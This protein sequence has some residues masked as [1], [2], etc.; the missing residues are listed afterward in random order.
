MENI[1]LFFYEARQQ[2]S[3]LLY[4]KMI[5]NDKIC[6]KLNEY[7]FYMLR[8]IRKES[9]NARSLPSAK[10]FVKRKQSLFGFNKLGIIGRI[11]V[12]GNI[13]S[14]IIT[15]RNS[16]SFSQNVSKV[17]LNLINPTIL[18]FHVS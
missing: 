12:E 18:F 15:I 6:L 5:S 7:I 11:L 2:T 9:L 10:V 3:N 16:V 4:Q 1:F 13:I 14:D 8:L 17:V